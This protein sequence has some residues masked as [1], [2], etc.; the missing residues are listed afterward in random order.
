MGHDV[1]VTDPNAWERISAI[2]DAALEVPKAE[3]P[4]VLE[5]LCDGDAALRTEVDSCLRAAEETAGFLD[6]SFP[7]QAPEFLAQFAQ[8]TEPA[9]L[10]PDFG[11][12]FGAYR[13]LRKI[14]EGGMGVVFEAEQKNPRRVVAL[15]I[16]RTRFAADRLS[17]RFALESQTL[18]R[19]QH[20]GIAQIF[21]AGIADT[22][23]GPQP[24]FAMELV[25]G[26]TFTEHA[27]AA[28][29]DARA[30][31]DLVA[32]I[33]DAVQHAHQR[34]VIHRDL[35]PD[36]I[37]V[38][39]SGAPKVLDF[40]VA[41]VTDADLRA[42]LVTDA[43]QMMGTLAYMSPE[44]VAGNPDEVDA[45][46]DVYAIGVALYELLAGRLPYD[47]RHRSLAES[48]RLIESAE[49]KPLGAVD[50]AY[51]G[52]IETIVAKAL[53][54][55]KHRRYASASDLADD[56]RRFL[57]REPI[58]ARPP[59]ATYVV[60]KLAERNRPLVLGV[61]AG[62]LMLVAGAAASAWQAVR[63]TR[64]AQ[65]SAAITGFLHQMLVSADPSEMKGRD[66]TVIDM[67]DEAA[68][69]LDDG[70]LE[71]RP[72]IE[73]YVR[74]TIGG[75]FFALGDFEAAEAQFRRS[76]ELSRAGLGERHRTVA[77]HLSDL[78]LA[79]RARGRAAEAESLLRGALE[80]NRDA[81]GGA[82]TST[83]AI[84]NNLGSLLRGRGARAGADS[85]YREALGIRLEVFGRE[86]DAVSETMNNL[87]TL[88]MDEGDLASAESL[89]TESLAIRRKILGPDHPE[90]ARILQ[91]LGGLQHLKE[92]YPQAETLTREALA[93]RRK[94]LGDEHPDVAYTLLLLAAVLREEEKFEE[95]TALAREAVAL[96]R[97]ALGSEHPLLG[98]SLRE[99]CVILLRAGDN[100]GADAAAREAMAIY[101]RTQPREHPDI[102]GC[103][104]LRARALLNAGHYAEAESLARFALSVFKPSQPSTEI[105]RFQATSILGGALTA[106]RR[107]AEAEPLVIEG[108]E[109]LM[110][111]FQAVGFGRRDALARVVALYES[112]G[113]LDAAAAWRARGERPENI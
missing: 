34:G 18:A 69:K 57:R 31:L 24:F 92:N 2:L 105:L 100:A 49:P 76:L 47:T 12:E 59:S 108:Y 104:T 1:H 44:Q 60:R 96:R 91:N 51:R 65:K 67:L 36:N 75:T 80:I 68:Q 22:P 74:S 103:E 73:A 5:R 97:K 85:M 30:R 39:E 83:A 45:R 14:G 87:A 88:R 9:S 112:W 4:A 58:V 89:Y 63:A 101:A 71:H 6:A 19:L 48:A 70:T 50:R 77:S 10:D 16:F 64:E 55:Q 106:Q 28:G 27:A 20:P 113:K 62:V 99:M 111:N 52:D 81:T 7:E 61:A 13:V 95:A 11:E 107:F 56:I 3:R 98:R 54:K 8:D 29:L 15:K 46:S 21:E 86:H 109:G 94:A 72:E 17:R 42:T 41:R 40:G 33:C 93:I 110:A 66:I 43:G 102:A 79:L 25:R 84:L 26:R 35:K 53:E 90:T 32:R 82:D 38:D 78:A 37:L 23:L